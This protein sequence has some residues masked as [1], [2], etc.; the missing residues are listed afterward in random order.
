MAR[1]T[2]NMISN[3][4]VPLRKFKKHFSMWWRVANSCKTWRVNFKW[5]LQIDPAGILSASWLNKGLSIDT[6]IGPI[7][8]TRNHLLSC[9]LPFVSKFIY[10]T[11]FVHTM[12]I[13]PTKYTYVIEMVNMVSRW[14]VHCRPI[15]WNK[16]SGDGP[17]YPPEAGPAVAQVWGNMTARVR[18]INNPRIGRLAAKVRPTS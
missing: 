6:T 15:S 12:D 16:Q 17:I 3:L 2:H 10:C 4:Y 1:H 8:L 7:H 9:Y 18:A 5:L 13:M 14:L 11:F